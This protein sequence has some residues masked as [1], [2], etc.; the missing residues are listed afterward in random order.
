MEIIKTISSVSM[1]TY[2]VRTV[3]GKI[4]LHSI[5]TT[6]PSEIVRRELQKIASTLDK[7]EQ[8]G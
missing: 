5:P 6:T 1:N 8:G 3:T 7:V 4:F 2:K